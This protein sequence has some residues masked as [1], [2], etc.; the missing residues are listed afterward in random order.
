MFHLGV[1]SG[2]LFLNLK[3]IHYKLQHRFPIYRKTHIVQLSK[4]HWTCQQKC[5]IKDD[6]PKNFS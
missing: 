5:F 2:K 1:L 4:L 6:K 3:P